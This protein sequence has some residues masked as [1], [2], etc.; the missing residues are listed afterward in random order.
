M[1]SLDDEVERMLRASVIENVAECSG[2]ALCRLKMAN[3]QHRVQRL[4]KARPVP[5]LAITEEHAKRII[6]ELCE[7]GWDQLETQL[8]WVPLKYLE[9]RKFFQDENLWLKNRTLRL[10]VFLHFRGVI[11]KLP[12]WDSDKRLKRLFDV[13]GRGW[14]DYILDQ[15]DIDFALKASQGLDLG[16]EQL[17]LRKYLEC[18]GR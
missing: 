18:S 13:F 5:E 6:L 1:L 10:G 8:A 15:D 9:F 7:G 11:C 12:N 17:W 16:D 3:L 4:E 2:V 14:G